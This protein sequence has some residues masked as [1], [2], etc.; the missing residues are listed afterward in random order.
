[1]SEGNLNKRIMS[2]LAGW[3]PHRVENAVGPGTP[4]IEYVGGHIESKQIPHWPKRPL[5][6]LRV[7][8]YVPE[9]RAWHIRRCQAGGRCHVVIEVERDVF[10]FDGIV[11]AQHLGLTMTRWGM[12]TAALLWMPNWNQTMFRRFIEQCNRDRV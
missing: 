12:Q 10:V 1:M 6:V 9:Q 11:A 5:S 3:D 2:A 7:P 8:H 4:D